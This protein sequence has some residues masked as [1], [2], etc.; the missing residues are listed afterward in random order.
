VIEEAVMISRSRSAPRAAAMS[1]ECTTSANNT[2]TC[3]YS[4]RVEGGVIG[5]PHLL[6]NRESS[7]NSV[8]RRARQP[9]SC[10]S[11]ATI[12]A[13]VHVSMVSPL[14]IDFRH[15]AVP[16]ST[17]SFET[18]ECRH[19]RDSRSGRRA[20]HPGHGSTHHAPAIYLASDS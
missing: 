11:T 10:Q 2:V 1:M 15:I 13:G 20:W 4:A 3:L 18:L 12:A 19:D 8:P 16:S 5:V 6:Q 9:C 14:V 17:P 7:G